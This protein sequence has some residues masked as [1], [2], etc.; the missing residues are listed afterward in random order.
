[1]K[2]CVKLGLQSS[3]RDKWKEA[4]YKTGGGRCVKKKRT[5]GR[6]ERGRKKISRTGKKG[7]KEDEDCQ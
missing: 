2:K 3:R 6:E 4:K 7:N 1:M 5:R